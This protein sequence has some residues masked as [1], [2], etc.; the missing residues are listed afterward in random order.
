LD[1]N[2]SALLELFSLIS[3]NTAVPNPDISSAFQA[4]QSVVAPSTSPDSRLIGATNQGYIQALQALEGAV[5]GMTVNPTSAN[6]PTAA[7]PVLQA[8][9]TAD[10]SAETLRNTFVPD[11]AGGMDRTSFAL[12]EDPIESTK[13]LAS[14]FGGVAAGGGAKTFCAQIA[15][16]LSKFP[17]NPQSPNEASTEEVAQIF[18]PGTGSFAQF[19]NATL[20]KLVVLQGSQYVPA[21]GSTVKISPAFLSFLDSAQKIQSTLF[22]SG[23][24]PSLD[25]TLSEVKAPGANDGILY[26]D[27][28]QINAAG[29]SATFHWVS[30]A[31]STITLATKNHN[32]SPMTGPW[33]VFHF[34]ST[35]TQ[36]PPNRLKFLFSLNKQTP[37]VVLFDVSG[38]G[39]PLLNPEFMQGFHCVSTVAH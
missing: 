2:T 34:A 21:P 17:F 7:A 24:Q 12:L 19:Y 18:A 20:N 35:A 33:S 16:V 8:A 11:P 14:N 36:V 15:P 1:S 5:K 28:K 37:E 22:V 27:G 38:P 23:N 3:T 31:S 30:Q 6:D 29:Q 32:A 13:S 39:A 26:I 10:G 9:L 4:P 25:F